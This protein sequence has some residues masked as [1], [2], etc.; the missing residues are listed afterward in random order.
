MMG[1]DLIES[2]HQTTVISI[3]TLEIMACWDLWQACRRNG[4]FG[5][6]FLESVW[7]LAG[8]AG[9]GAAFKALLWGA[10]PSS[11]ETRFAP[12][13][14]ALCSMGSR[15]WKEVHWTSNCLS[16]SDPPE[17]SHE[18]SMPDT[19]IVA[20]RRFSR[21]TCANHLLFHVLYT[22]RRPVSRQMHIA[23][24]LHRLCIHKAFYFGQKLKINAMQI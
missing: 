2:L 11:V 12:P 21:M 14:I 24:Q 10:D 20:K 23:A 4:S 3:E 1:F 6:F 19:L 16:S 9:A 13:F 18:L 5:S 15:T 7:D 17:A 22:M 8:C